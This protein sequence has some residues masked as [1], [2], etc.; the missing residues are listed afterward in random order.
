MLFN[1]ENLFKKKNSLLSNNYTFVHNVHIEIVC[2][3]N[4]VLCKVMILN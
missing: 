2:S 3:V 1:Y 4:F